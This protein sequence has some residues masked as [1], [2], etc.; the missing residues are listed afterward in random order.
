MPKINV[1]IVCYDNEVIEEVERTLSQFG[2]ILE[3][4]R[5]KVVSQFYHYR[6]ETSDGEGLD[7]VLREYLEKDLISWYK[8]EETFG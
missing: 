1:Y 4:N 2:K 8:I 3:K 6:M 7:R 5:S